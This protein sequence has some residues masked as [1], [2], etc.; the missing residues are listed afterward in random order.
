VLLKRLDG[1]RMLV[2]RAAGYDQRTGVIGARC[3]CPH[4]RRAAGAV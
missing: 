1:F 4:R 3:D 2:R